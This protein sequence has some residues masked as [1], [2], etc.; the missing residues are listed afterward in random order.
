MTN[1]PGTETARY[2]Q[3]VHLMMDEP[4]RAAVLGLAALTAKEAGPQ[5][6]PKEG[7]TLRSLLDSAL[8]EIRKDAPSLYDNAVKLGRQ[9]LARRSKRS[10]P[11]PQ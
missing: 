5:V 2:S 9:E 4:S 11:R 6:R 8:N 1:T 7:E 3:S 10:R